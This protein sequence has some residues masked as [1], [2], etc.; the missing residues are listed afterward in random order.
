MILSR[1]RIKVRYLLPAEVIPDHEAWNSKAERGAEG[2]D[3]RGAEGIDEQGGKHGHS[4]ML[5]K[6]IAESKPEKEDDHDVDPLFV[7][8]GGFVVRHDMGFLC[9]GQ[10]AIGSMPFAVQTI[11][12]NDVWRDLNMLEFGRT[13]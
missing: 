12:F 6:D 4:H 2:I 11:L 13:V 3:E 9:E 1:G 5:M 7:V 8:H 10:F